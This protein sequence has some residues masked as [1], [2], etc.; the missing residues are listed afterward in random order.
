MKFQHPKDASTKNKRTFTSI[1][2][3]GEEHTEMDE[4]TIN[5]LERSEG[6]TFQARA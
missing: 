1:E 4:E 6:C 5:G 2:E 3:E